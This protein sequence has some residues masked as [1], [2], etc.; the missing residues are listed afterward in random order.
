MTGGTDGIGLEV[1]RQLSAAGADLVVVGRRAP[2]NVTLP[3]GCRYIQAD[4][5]A[6]ESVEIIMSDL[7]Q[8]EFDREFDHLVLNASIGYVGSVNEEDDIALLSLLN[9]N[10][11]GPFALCQRLFPALNARSG[12]VCFIGSTAADRATPD[13]ASYTASK[14]AIRDLADNLET[15]WHG[16]VKVQLLSP[17]PTR[18]AFHEKAGM[19]LPPLASLFMKPEEV[20][21]GVVQML[22]SGRRRKRYSFFSLLLFAAKRRLFGAIS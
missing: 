18:T 17:G 22:A 3:D 19:D 16:R 8:I 14:T 5:S 7:E 9:V 1:A 10:L 4:L 11:K 15:E 13:F 12:S 2:K 21:K 20:A 6:P